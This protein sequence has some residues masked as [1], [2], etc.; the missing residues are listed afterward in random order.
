MELFKLTAQ[1]N[2]THIP[3]SGSAGA[4]KDLLAGEVS[5]MFLPIHTTL[6]LA[7]SGK[8]RILA[9]GSKV[10]AQQAKLVSTLVE[11]GMTDFDVDLW[12][13]ALAPAGT[14]REVV[15][16]YNAVLNEVL[17]QPHVRAV[18]EKQGLVVQGGPPERLSDLIAKDRFALGQSG[19]GCRH[20]SG[21]TS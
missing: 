2:L 8:M 14:P 15:D 3:Y 5:A 4:V 17:A 20:H 6:P 18:L 13:G 7:E 9:V 12:F 10:R 16:R 11:L 21:L 1:V 19:Q